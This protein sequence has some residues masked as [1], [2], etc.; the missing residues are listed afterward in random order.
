MKKI[1]LTLALCISINAN[2][3][4]PVV[5]VGSITQALIQVQQLRDQIQNQIAQINS[6]QNQYK[7]VTGSRNLGE[8]FNNTQLRNYLPTD[9]S[10]L[11]DAIQSGNAQ[12]IANSISSLQAKEDQ[13]NKASAIKR[14]ETELL[15][16]KA[17]STDALR[18]QSGRLDN[19]EKLMSQ[20]NYAT[21]AK[22]SA[23]LMNRIAIES[24]LVQA[25]GNRIALMSQLSQANQKL[26][27]QQRVQQSK[28][29]LIYGG[30]LP[31]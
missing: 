9:Y 5:D 19:I 14:S 7:A 13:Y 28:N 20:I 21:D 2:A 31:Q 26:A 11:Y 25:E 4:V 27:D 30:S 23:D 3:G 12:D 15:M 16:Q 17:V 10:K 29:R 6:L 8:L 18:A 22:A 1:I 24:S